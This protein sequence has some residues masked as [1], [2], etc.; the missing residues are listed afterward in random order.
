M[1][2]A[3]TAEFHVTFVNHPTF[4]HAKAEGPRT[5]ENT[6]RFLREAHAA[7]VVAGVRDVL[8]E[9]S[10]TGPGFETSTIYKIVNQRAPE[11][12]KLRRIA[13]VENAPAATR[14]S[15]VEDLAVNRGV[16]VKLFG[17]VDAAKRWLTE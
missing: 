13:Y 17:D 9:M 6:L 16:N 7:C 14:T 3:A 5:P 2:P 10:L 12:V 11:G 8:V 1:T 15:F 4:V